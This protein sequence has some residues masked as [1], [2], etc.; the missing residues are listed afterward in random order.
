MSR[1]ELDLDSSCSRLRA[2]QKLAPR[3]DLFPLSALLTRTNDQLLTGALPSR[4]EFIQVRT[5]RHGL[6]A[7]WVCIEHRV[8]V[9]FLRMSRK[10]PRVVACRSRERSPRSARRAWSVPLQLLGLQRRGRD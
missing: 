3:A 1:L 7:W 9:G 2:T 6:L 8:L 4:V 5:V 10:E